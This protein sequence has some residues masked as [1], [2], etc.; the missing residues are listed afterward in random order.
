MRAS[1]LIPACLAFAACGGEKAET[2]ATPS[3]PPP[4]VSDLPAPWN[5]ADLGKGKGVFNKC[6]SCHTVGAGQANLVGP[7]LHGVFDRH[8]GT[9]SKFKYSPAMKAWTENQWTPE[10]VDHWLQKPKDF[11]PGTAMFFDGIA[12]EEDRRDLIAFLLIETRK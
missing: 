5:A 4:A 1:Y 11:M 6:R 8:P 10:L 7:N 2:T 12:K 9:A 3:V